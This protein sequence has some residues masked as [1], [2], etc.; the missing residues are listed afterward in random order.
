[1]TPLDLSVLLHHHF[2]TESHPKIKSQA[3]QDSIEKLLLSNSLEATGHPD[4]FM[5][6]DNGKVLIQRL[7]SVGTY[8]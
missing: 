4:C 5:V 8:L 7:C 2:T 6:T 1:M 3:T